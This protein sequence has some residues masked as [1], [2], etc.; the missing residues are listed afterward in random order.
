MTTLGEV[1]QLAWVH[2]WSVS[3]TRHHLW[4]KSGNLPGYMFDQS[5]SPWGLIAFLERSDNLPGYVLDDQSQ[6]SQ[7]TC[8]GHTWG[9]SSIGQHFQEKSDNLPWYVLYY[10]SWK[11]SENWPKY[12]F[13]ESPQWDITLS[14][15][16]VQGKLDNL[17]GNHIHLHVLLNLVHKYR[18]ICDGI[19]L[20]ALSWAVVLERRVHAI[21]I[22]VFIFWWTVFSNAQTYIMIQV[23]WPLRR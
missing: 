5:P 17:S 21:S 12:R 14:Y 22:S 6:Q 9:V 15:T 23:C 8:P 1:S 3:P 13:H 7:T 2:T 19:G 16:S 11:K 18:D 10:Q 20:L 4:R